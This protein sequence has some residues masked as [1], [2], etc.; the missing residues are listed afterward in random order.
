MDDALDPTYTA[1]QGAGELLNGQPEE[2]TM[3]ASRRSLLQAG[4]VAAAAGTLPL[5]AAQ[6][7]TAQGAGK[8]YVLVHGAWHGGWCWKEVAEALRGMGHRVTTPTQ[9]GLG[10]RKHLLSG[11]IT[12]DT[13]VADVVNHIEAEELTDVILVGHSFGGT[14]ISGAA[15]KVPSRIRHLVYLDAVL[16]ESGKSVFSALPPDIVAARKKMVAEQGQGI[17]IPVPAPTAFG[18]PAEHASVEWLKRRLTPHPVGTYDSPLNL[19]NPVGNGRPRTYIACTNPAYGPLEST[20]QAVK[21]QDGWKWQEIATGH[22][23]MVTA[24]AELARMLAAIG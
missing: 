24:P 8:T 21:K 1:R 19:A 18:I 16:L 7:A 13:F 23:A 20:R 4:M 6:T 12:L 10:E 11:S 2:T 15:D 22:D 3:D 5:A 14:S 9:T 17:F